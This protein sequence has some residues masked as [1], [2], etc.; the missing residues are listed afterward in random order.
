MTWTADHWHDGEWQA[1]VPGHDWPEWWGAFP[2]HS[3]VWNEG[4]EH[5]VRLIP[6]PLYQSRMRIPEPMREAPE[7]GAR[8]Y[9]AVAQALDKSAI[10]T[11]DDSTWQLRW[12]ALGLFYLTEADAIARAEAMSQTE[13]GE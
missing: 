1:R 2:E 5:R 8:I 10:A 13:A 3:P 11:W 6:K 7:K 9:L 4:Y 12:L